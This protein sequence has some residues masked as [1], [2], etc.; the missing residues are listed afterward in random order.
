MVSVVFFKK[1]FVYFWLSGVFTAARAFL[2]VGE[3]GGHVLAVVHE[4]LIVVAALVAE[5]GL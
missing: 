4:L 2:L 1:I 5:N 3:S